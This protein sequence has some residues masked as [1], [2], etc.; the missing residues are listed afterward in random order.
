MTEQLYGNYRV[1]RKLGEG[2]MGVVFEAVHDQIG[3]RAAVKVLQANFANDAQLSARFLTEARAVD[4]VHHPGLVSIFEF[5]RTDEG[6]PYLVMEYLD[7]P[8]LRARMDAQRPLPVADTR[9]IMRQISSALAAA[10]EKNVVHRDLKPDNVMLVP[11][12]ELPG[13]ERAK[14]LDFG[15]AK[16]GEDHR[17]MTQAGAMLGT[18][19]YMAPEQCLG[20]GSVDEKADIYA[21]GVMLFELLAGVLPFEAEG[22]TSM[23]VMHLQAQPRPL[24]DFLSD[25]P[26]DLES[27]VAR[28]LAKTPADR[29]SAREVARA[30]DAVPVAAEAPPI[31]KSAAPA[32]STGVGVVD[33]RELDLPRPSAGQQQPGSNDSVQPELESG[34]H[35]GRL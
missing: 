19:A 25:V 8:T 24:R 34:G 31:A 13:G 20:A 17:R 12:P 23:M 32:L 21:L 29:P 2:G 27:L 7:G 22:P 35:R 4:M 3:K 28:M 11:E 33:G 14:I 10:H 18:P 16:L 26:R 30:M 1:V 15:I 6:A 9:R 5:G